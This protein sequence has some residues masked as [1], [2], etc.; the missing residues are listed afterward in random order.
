MPTYQRH[1]AALAALHIFG[2]AALL[3]VLGAPAWA[4]AAW[5]L[6]HVRYPAVKR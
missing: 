2:G 5:L 3:S 6:L 4:L 1:L